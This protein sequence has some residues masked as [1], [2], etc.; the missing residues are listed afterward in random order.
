[1][2]PTQFRGG[3]ASL[4]CGTR[5]SSSSG[6]DRPYDE[7]S[8]SDSVRTPSEAGAGRRVLSHVGQDSHCTQR[9]TARV[10]YLTSAGH[11]CAGGQG[12]D[13]AGD[14]ENQGEKS[15]DGGPGKREHKN[16]DEGD[17]GRGG[18]EKNGAPGGWQNRDGG[19]DGDRHGGTGGS[20][21]GDGATTSGE[22]G[23]QDDRGEGI[24]E[25]DD[26]EGEMEECGEDEDM[27]TF[28]NLSQI[29]LCDGI[30]VL[31]YGKSANMSR[32]S[33]S[34][35]SSI[36]SRSSGGGGENSL[37]Q[38][39]H[40]S[41]FFQS[42]HALDSTPR[43]SRRSGSYSMFDSTDVRAFSS[44]A[45][46]TSETTTS[47]LVNCE[48]NPSLTTP[49]VS[50]AN[51]IVPDSTFAEGHA[52]I[53]HSSPV[54]RSLPTDEPLAIMRHVEVCV[55]PVLAEHWRPGAQVE[56]VESKETE[57]IEEE[58]EQAGVCDAGD[59]EDSMGGD[60]GGG[61][62]S[63]EEWLTHPDSDIIA[64]ELESWGVNS[65]DTLPSLGDHERTKPSAIS[66]QEEGP[67]CVETATMSGHDWAGLNE[68]GSWRTEVARQAAGEAGA[69]EAERRRLAKINADESWRSG[70]GEADGMRCRSSV[71]RESISFTGLQTGNVR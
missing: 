68:D 55:D 52:S 12:E 50:D 28:L 22:S 58:K 48:D 10:A 34:L 56:H 11:Q 16:D 7:S 45:S 63:E 59:R 37:V 67:K 30:D 61:G 21:D 66:T 6:L 5:L 39:R 69:V 29:E 33:A 15:A 51:A 20:N 4:L 53:H 25:D 23:T 26:G 54:V 3:A 8:G 14:D 70:D 13:G 2:K 27:D 19:G 17:S 31:Q 46:G 49:A 38:P 44:T 9:S 41:D 47:A 18:D 65:E 24:D 57:A 62:E 32:N 43:S 1:M 64:P 40:L 71:R 36:G 60:G 35:D 42:P